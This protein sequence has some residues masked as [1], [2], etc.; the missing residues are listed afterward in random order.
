MKFYD[1]CYRLTSSFQSLFILFPIMCRMSFFASNMVSVAEQ[2]DTRSNSLS[3]LH[4]KGFRSVHKA[5]LYLRLEREI[6]Y[7]TTPLVEQPREN[8]FY[9]DSSSDDIPTVVSKLLEESKKI[10]ENC[11]SIPECSLDCSVQ[12]YLSGLRVE[13]RRAELLEQA[14]ENAEL[15]EEYRQEM[16]SLLA[17]ARKNLSASSSSSESSSSSS[18]SSSSSSESSSSSSESSS[19]SYD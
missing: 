12:Q 6:G 7:I 4:N 5:N 18:E 10:F 1:L 13:S 14:N 15:A 2:I 11:G 17:D 16:E 3:D 9:V 8:L 19:T